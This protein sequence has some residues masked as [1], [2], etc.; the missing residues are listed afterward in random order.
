MMTFF[1][2]LPLSITFCYAFSSSNLRQFTV[3]KYE[4]HTFNI[5]LIVSFNN[6]GVFICLTQYVKYVFFEYD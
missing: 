5:N 3:Y 4:L 2:D 6:E 1:I